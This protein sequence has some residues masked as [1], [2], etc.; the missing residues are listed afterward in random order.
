MSELN[1]FFDQAEEEQEAHDQNE[2]YK[3]AEANKG[4][5]WNG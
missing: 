3:R 2:R 4:Q 1:D 5:I